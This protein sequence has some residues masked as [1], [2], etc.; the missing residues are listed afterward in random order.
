[1]HESVPT[2]I[3]PRNRVTRFEQVV[4]LCLPEMGFISRIEAK[5]RDGKHFTDGLGWHEEFTIAGYTSVAGST[6]V[7]SK[8]I[9]GVVHFEVCGNL[10]ITFTGMMVL[11]SDSGIF[12]YMDGV[13]LVSTPDLERQ[14]VEWRGQ[15]VMSQNNRFQMEVPFQVKYR[16]GRTSF[17]WQSQEITGVSKCLERL[18]CDS[19]MCFHARSDRTRRDGYHGNNFCANCLVRSNPEVI[20]REVEYHSRL[21]NAS[22]SRNRPQRSS[23]PPVIANFLRIPYSLIQSCL[24]DISD[25]GLLSK[26]YVDGN[27][28]FAPIPL[29]CQKVLNHFE[30]DLHDFGKTVHSS[31]SPLVGCPMSDYC[32]PLSDSFQNSVKVTPR[33]K[34]GGGL[35][36]EHSE[37]VPCS[38]KQKVCPTESFWNSNEMKSWSIGDKSRASSAVNRAFDR[39]LTDIKLNTKSSYYLDELVY[40]TTIPS[41]CKFGNDHIERVMWHK[42]SH[43]PFESEALT[44]LVPL[45]GSICVSLGSYRNSSWSSSEI[46]VKF[47]DYLI[48]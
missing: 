34:I 4:V 36:D 39:I 14:P 27:T 23:S 3:L 13:F 29:E 42:N 11:D 31:P 5:N 20:W 26:L 1:M 2:I 16:S 25:L 30:A 48:W 10:D 46:S 7:G 21:L 35:S 22:V 15:V 6:L 38:K 9:R 18:P 12:R 24:R 17:V 41:R 45:K 37:S 47:G 40:H 28:N 8:V 32:P 43:H 19:P 44:V 33:I